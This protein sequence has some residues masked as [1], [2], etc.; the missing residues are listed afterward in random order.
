MRKIAP[1]SSKIYFSLSP[2]RG[3]VERRYTALPSRLIGYRL[4]RWLTVIPVWEKGLGNDR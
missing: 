1:L 4:D 3:C 2:S